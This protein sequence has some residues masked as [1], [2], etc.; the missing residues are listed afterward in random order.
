MT[1]KMDATLIILPEFCFFIISDTVRVNRN[2][3]FKLTLLIQSQSFDDIFDI[4]SILFTPALLIKTSIFL[5]LF[6]ALR[7][8]FKESSEW[9]SSW[10]YRVL[11]LSETPCTSGLVSFVPVTSSFAPAFKNNLA[12]AAPMPRVP[13]VIITFLLVKSRWFH[14]TWIQMEHSCYILSGDGTIRIRLGNIMTHWQHLSRCIHSW[15][16]QY[17]NVEKLCKEKLY[18]DKLWSKS[19]SSVEQRDS[20]AA[21]AQGIS[22][23]KYRRWMRAKFKR[24]LWNSPGT[25]FNFH[26]VP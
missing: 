3:P 26:L 23:G 25:L 16:E 20:V 17:L 8:L 9:R 4:D 5:S 1:P 7:N 11:L 18:P 14:A 10:W 13:P 22:H 12:I 21:T 6:K 24:R 19:A 2:G 15:Y